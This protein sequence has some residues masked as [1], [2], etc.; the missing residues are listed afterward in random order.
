MWEVFW[1]EKGYFHG[2]LDNNRTI[3]IENRWNYCIS[4][5]ERGW[6]KLVNQGL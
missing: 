2:A 3:K 6:F 4:Y 5:S 1:R